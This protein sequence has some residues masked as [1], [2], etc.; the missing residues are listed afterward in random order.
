MTN[1]SVLDNRLSRATAVSMFERLHGLRP[2]T[3]HHALALLEVL[4]VDVRMPGMSGPELAGGAAT[5]SRYQAGTYL[6][7]RR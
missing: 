4:F 6:G 3:G 2:Y 7:V 5:P 1:A